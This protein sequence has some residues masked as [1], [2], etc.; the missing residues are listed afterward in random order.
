MS[1]PDEPHRHLQSN[2]GDHNPDE[3]LEDF[4]EKKKLLISWPHYF[5]HEPQKEFDVGL[6][7]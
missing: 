4:K 7:S 6:L 2:Y 5:P 1:Q 3:Y